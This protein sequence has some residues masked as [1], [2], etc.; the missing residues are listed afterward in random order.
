MIRE[1]G[2]IVA[3]SQLVSSL[4]SRTRRTQYI[5]AYNQYYAEQGN[6]KKSLVTGWDHE[7]GGDLREKRPAL[8]RL[9]ILLDKI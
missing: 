5:Y 1:L 9:E 6:T 2:A 8:S 4:G 3:I 7:K